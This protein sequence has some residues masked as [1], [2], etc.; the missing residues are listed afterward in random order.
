M[1]PGGQ[2]NWAMDWVGILRRISA[3]AVDLVFPPVC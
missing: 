2:E 3:Q 1:K